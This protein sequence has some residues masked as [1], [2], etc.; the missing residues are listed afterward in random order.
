M[1]HWSANLWDEQKGAQARAYLKQ[2]QITEESAKQWQLGLAVDAWDDL[3]AKA[4]E[5]RDA[6]KS[7]V[8]GR[9]GGRKGTR[10]LLRQ[11]S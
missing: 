2:R 10:R 3:V 8:T 5:K 9:V 1:N 7:L 6:S 4:S 11:V